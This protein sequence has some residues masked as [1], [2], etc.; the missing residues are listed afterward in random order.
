MCNSTSCNVEAEGHTYMANACPAFEKV[1]QGFLGRPSVFGDPIILG[2]T[3][4]EVGKRWQ[5]PSTFQLA[6]VHILLP[7]MHSW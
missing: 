1:T 5:Y 4:S 3:F 6:G 2:P 7:I